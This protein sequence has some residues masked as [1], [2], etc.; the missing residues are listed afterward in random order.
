[1]I[2]GTTTVTT[3]LA[4]AFASSTVDAA[5]IKGDM[6]QPCYDYSETFGDMGPDECNSRKLFLRI[7]DT[8][9]E[10]K[11]LTGNKCKGGINRDLMAL[12]KSDSVDAAHAYLQDLCDDA[13]EDAIDAANAKKHTWENLQDAPA[14]IDMEVFFDGQGFLNDETGNFQQEEKTFIK[15]GGYE[16]FNYIGED[17]RLNDHYPTSEASYVAGEAIWQFYENEASSAYLTAPTVS[18][19]GG[20][21]QT[22][23]AV[24]CWHRDRQ[25]FDKNGNCAHTDCANQN[26]GDN[27]DL[28]W[29][30]TDEGAFPYPD[31]VAEGDLHCHGLSWG[32]TIDQTAGDVNTNARWNNLFFV[33][34]YDHLYTRGYV[35]SI[36]DNTLIAGDEAMCGCVEDMDF[37]VARADCTEAVGKTNYTTSLDSEGLLVARHIADTFALEFRA[38]EGYDYDASISPR[39]FETDYNFNGEDAGLTNSNNDLSAFYFRQYLEGLIDEEHVL[40]YEKTIVGYRDPTVNDGDDERNA[41]CEA[42]FIEKFNQ[43]FVEREVEATA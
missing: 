31:D 24:C 29:T 2:F 35:D 12:T 18:F 27:T 33:S 26:P 32:N 16:R 42:K 23:A 15:K 34:L 13:L 41:V 30:D 28:C 36:T 20:C 4:V 40:E 39:Q 7:R 38:C 9:Q 25:Y 21:P 10:Q 19:E 11:K 3:F 6:T 14:S 43:E 22:N 17:P 5:T 8:H 1:M 37:A